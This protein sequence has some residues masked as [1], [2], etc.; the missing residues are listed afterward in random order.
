MCKPTLMEVA[1]MYP[2]GTA[3]T[4]AAAAILLAPVVFGI[5]VLWQD[6]RRRCKLNDQAI[7]IAAEADSFEARFEARIQAHQKRLEAFE[8]TV[9][10]S[11]YRR[12][13]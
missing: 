13:D 7:A 1:T 12:P 3:F 8:Q 11:T 6:W 4:I 10:P 2:T 5:Y 9:Q